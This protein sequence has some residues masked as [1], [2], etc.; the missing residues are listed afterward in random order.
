MGDTPLALLQRLRSAALA[1]DLQSL[2][3][4]GDDLAAVDLSPEMRPE[5]LSSLR[6]AAGQALA[7][8]QAA[9]AG[10]AATRALLENR[11]YA[12]CLYTYGPDGHLQRLL[13]SRPAIA[14]L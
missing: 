12:D 8:M 7:L 11:A 5:D 6:A 2:V 10:V 1:G 14:R 13:P 3:Q 4:L 9:A